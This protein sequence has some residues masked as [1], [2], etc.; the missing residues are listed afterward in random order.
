MTDVTQRPELGLYGRHA[1]AAEEM[2]DWPADFLRTA[3]HFSVVPRAL[4][5]TRRRPVS[6]RDG[7]C[8]SDCRAP[9][10]VPRQKQRDHGARGVR[11][12][13]RAEPQSI[14]GDKGRA[15]SRRLASD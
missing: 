13:V 11:Q 1:R 14:G 7:H 5:T 9:A 10:T 15:P 12:A 2:L 6:L 8:A 3:E 4:R